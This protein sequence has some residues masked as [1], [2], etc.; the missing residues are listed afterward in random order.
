MQPILP[1]PPLH[2]QLPREIISGELTSLPGSLTCKVA[3]VQAVDVA[4]D[5]KTLC[6]G[7]HGRSLA[8]ISSCHTPKLMLLLLLTSSTCSQVDLLMAPH[9]SCC[10]QFLLAV[11]HPPPSKG[12]LLCGVARTPL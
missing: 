3:L 2:L 11:L 5:P 8:Q 10:S 9:T 7:R 1:R 4:V 12:I 6:L